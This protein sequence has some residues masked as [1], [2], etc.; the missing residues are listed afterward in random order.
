MAVEMAKL[1]LWLLTLAKGK[2][3]TFLD[4]AIKRGDSLLGVSQGQLQAFDLHPSE[5]AANHVLFLDETMKKVARLRETAAMITAGGLTDVERQQKHLAAAEHEAEKLKAAADILLSDAFS[6][7]DDR[8]TEQDHE[9]ALSLYFGD[10]ADLKERAEPFRKQLQAFHWP[11]EFP[12]VFAFQNGFDA[13]I[14]NPP[15]SGGAKITGI[16]GVPYRE[17][18]IQYLANGCRGSADYSAYFFLRAS[19]LITRDG[20]FGLL[21]TNSIAQGGTREVGLDQIS[22][23]SIIRAVS[24][25]KWP[26][27]AANLHYSCVWATPATW[28]GPVVLDDTQVDRIGTSLSVELIRLPRPRKL[29]GQIKSF[30]GSKLVG[31]G[32]MLS[33]E[34][35]L[36]LIERN[37]KSSDVLLPYLNAND[38]NSRWNQTASRWAIFFR[39]WPLSR[40]AEG[41]WAGALAEQR[42]KWRKV[43]HVPS[44]YPDSVADDY[45]ECLSIL[46]AT[47]KEKRGA[48]KYSD[49]TRD[50]WWQFERLRADLYKEISPLSKVLVTG[51]VSA[52]HF[53]GIV[54][55]NQLFSDRLVVFASDQAFLFGALSSTIHDVWAHRPGQTTHE[56]RPT[57]FHKGAFQ[58]FPFP[59]SSERLDLMC[60]RFSEDRGALLKD[61][62]LGL[63]T[64]YERL[65]D[66]SIEDDSA[67]YFRAL[68]IE[69]DETVSAAYGWS[70][71]LAHDFYETNQGQR[72]TISPAAKQQVLDRLLRLNHLKAAASKK[73]RKKA[74]SRPGGLFD[75]EVTIA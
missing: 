36:E 46:R 54:P 72:F 29:H 8:R 48:T 32:F 62:R 53:I 73:P 27:K 55:N 21:A 18:L 75:T 47:V 5:K 50:K 70:F 14:G 71:D 60:G 56:T 12:E 57:Y 68:Q 65:H 10:L 28:A 52:Y 7:K 15:F 63:R 26:G 20:L 42:K 33:R 9:I 16:R 30:Q 43:G 11:L 51:R 1:S 64:L 66:S 49:S 25:R 74:A 4:H 17:Y 22:D 31:K 38:L 24:S 59:E 3:F 44:D 40:D 34:A 58:T 6:N 37:P 35:A 67:R 23:C 2:P 13:I 69:L 19:R 61:G 41:E 45:P 39:D